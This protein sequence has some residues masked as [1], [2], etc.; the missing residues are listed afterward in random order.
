MGFGR[1]RAEDSLGH[2]GNAC[3][4]QTAWVQGLGLRGGA[5]RGSDVLKV[6]SKG[7]G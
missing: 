2:G 6:W 4:P 7:L 3:F 1:F 5:L